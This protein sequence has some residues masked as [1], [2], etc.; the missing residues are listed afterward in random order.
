MTPKANSGRLD[1]PIPA[2]PGEDRTPLGRL[3]LQQRYREALFGEALLHKL[4]FKV[5]F[6]ASL[7]P[8]LWM[9]IGPVDA[10]E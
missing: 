3:L 10:S 9:Y 4:P 6:Q 5:G 1:G 7:Y 8:R 2:L